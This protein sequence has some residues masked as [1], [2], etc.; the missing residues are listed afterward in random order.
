M[1]PKTPA[2]LIAT[3]AAL[4]LPAAT[5][6]RAVP[7]PRVA[8]TAP[9]V[10]APPVAITASAPSQARKVRTLIARI[11]AR[12]GLRRLRPERHLARAARAHSADMRRRGYFSHD[13]PDGR[14]PADR[15]HA[16]GYRRAAADGEIIAYGTGALSSPRALVRAWMRSPSHR[17]AILS[18][19]FR[20]IGVGVARAGRRAWAT[21]DF[22]T[23]RG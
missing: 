8:T 4:A 6:A 23:R 9:V 19:Q 21:A 10:P 3:V 11:R 12:H 13:S 18:G 16:A 5:P 17:D 7:A 20:E 22:G 2:A 14:T 15:I 1:R